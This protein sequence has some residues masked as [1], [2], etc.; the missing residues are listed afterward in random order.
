MK[1]R[2]SGYST[3]QIQ[4]YRLCIDMLYTSLVVQDDMQ[5]EGSYLMLAR[6]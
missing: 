5:I 6:E 3:G 1:L 2:L 4:R